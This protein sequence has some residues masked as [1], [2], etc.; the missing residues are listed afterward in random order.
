MLRF[1]MTVTH[2]KTNLCEMKLSYIDTVFEFKKEQRKITLFHFIKF[3]DFVL[4]CLIFLYN[5]LKN[6]MSLT[7]KDFKSIRL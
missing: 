5:I 6:I 2:M 7:I 3:D 1:R 4:N